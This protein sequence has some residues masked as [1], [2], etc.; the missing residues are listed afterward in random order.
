MGKKQ[1]NS[2][3]MRY[4]SWEVKK[5]LTENRKSPI[6]FSKGLLSFNYYLIF[7]TSK[8]YTLTNL[9]FKIW[10]D[11]FGQNIIKTYLSL[12]K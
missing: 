5:D 10:K 7:F 4:L 12:I 3:M 6:R 9:A 11:I 2:P 8:A 1:R